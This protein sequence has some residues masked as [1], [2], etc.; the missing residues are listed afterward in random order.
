MLSSM[1][2]T[3]VAFTM[4]GLMQAVMALIWLLGS[5][6][7]GDTRRAAVHW[8]AYAALSAL[9]FVLLTAAL[10]AQGSPATDL[11]RGFGNIA[12]FL[13]LIALQRGIWLF[14]GRPMTTTGHWLAVAAVLVAS[15]I[16]LSPSGG[17]IRVGVNSIV[18]ALL[19]FGMAYDLRIF[20]R[21]QLRLHW[22][23]VLAL[24]LLIA[25]LSFLFRGSRALLVPGAVNAEMAADSALNVGSALLYVVLALAFHATLVALVVSRLVLELRHRSRHDGLT[26]LLNRRAM[27]EA[28]HAQ[29]QRSRR[30]GETFTVLMLDLDYFKSI[31]DRFGHAAG[32]RALRHAAGLLKAGL[33]EVDHLAR[34]GG[35]EFLALLPGA[36]LAAA[37]PLAE[38]LR[39]CLDAEPLVVESDRVPLSVSIGVAQWTDASEDASRLLV[40][41]DA[42]LYQAKLQGRNRVV[43]AVSGLL[44][45]QPG[46]A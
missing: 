17:S 37:Q 21:D 26:G 46:S 11:L 6:L 7:V 25:A 13:A 36:S 33:R 8:A 41:A 10:H 15:Y 20:A 27:E 38:R 40:R 44:W 22:P 12:G 45:T 14:I 43:T 5:W 31:N 34:F 32:D 9:S 2:A 39:G 3:D 24:P 30:T 23:S 1:S 18:Q 16:G 4:A 28:L 29:V 35:E 42:A 19:A